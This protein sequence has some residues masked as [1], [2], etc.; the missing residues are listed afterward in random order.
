MAFTERK[1]KQVKAR[2]IAGKVMEVLDR[3]GLLV[4]INHKGLEDWNGKKVMVNELTGLSLEEQELLEQELLE[5][6]NLT[7]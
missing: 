4:K 1:V 2:L 3:K 5:Q 6:I 7:I